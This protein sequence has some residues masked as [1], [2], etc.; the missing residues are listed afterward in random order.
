MSR[1][2]PF[3]TAA[4]MG[5]AYF[6]TIIGGMLMTLGLIIALRGIVVKGSGV[7]NFHLKTLLLIL[8]SITLFGLTLEFFGLLCAVLILV[9]LASIGGHEFRMWETLLV[10][11]CLAAGSVAVFVFF[12]KLQIPIWIS[13]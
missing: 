1:S 11:V 13:F 5:P 6:P 9:V 12:L 7:G 3:G 8:A 10:S 4:R 2:L